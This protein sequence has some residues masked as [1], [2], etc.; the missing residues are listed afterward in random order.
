MANLITLIRFPL[1]FI[2]LLLIYFGGPVAAL[3]CVPLVAFIFYLDT[4]D[5]FVA[6]ILGEVS[7]LGSALDIATDRTLEIVLWVAFADLKLIPVIIPLI[8]IVRGTTVDAIR[9]VGIGQ[10]TAA[11][12]QVKHP[13]NRFLVSSRFMRNFYGIT[14]AVAFVF[15]TLSLWLKEAFLPQFPTILLV[16]EI[17]SWITITLTVVR[18]LPVLIEGYQLFR[19]KKTE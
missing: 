1:I 17:L 19:V 7:L 4:I 16:A 18:G 6:R 11:F 13:F 15:L 12:D 8:A 9:A 5:G 10:G 3:W 14:K 2:Y